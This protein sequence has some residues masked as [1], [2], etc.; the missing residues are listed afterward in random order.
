MIVAP[1][2]HLSKE[3]NFVN[4]FCELKQNSIHLKKCSGEDVAEPYYPTK[5]CKVEK[6]KDFSMTF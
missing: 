5:Q 3:S 6:K 4:V 2:E 1:E